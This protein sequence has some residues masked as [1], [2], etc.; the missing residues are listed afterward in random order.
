MPARIDGHSESVRSDPPCRVVLQS[1]VSSC[2][3][4]SLWDEDDSILV[5]NDDFVDHVSV[6]NIRNVLEDTTLFGNE[7]RGTRYDARSHDQVEI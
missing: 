7:E 5:C 3:S 4:A 2:K 6:D 1:S